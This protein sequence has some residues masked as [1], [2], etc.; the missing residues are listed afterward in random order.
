MSGDAGVPA[1]SAMGAA[2]TAAV[3]IGAPDIVAVTGLN[4]VYA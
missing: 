2:A 4:D 1:L 3:N